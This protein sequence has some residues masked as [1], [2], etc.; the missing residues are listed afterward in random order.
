MPYKSPY[1]LA[2]ADRLLA[3]NS[4]LLPRRCTGIHSQNL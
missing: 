1:G 4:P 2:E 3:I